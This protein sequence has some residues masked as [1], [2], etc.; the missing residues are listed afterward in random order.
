M[1]DLMT[2]DWEEENDTAEKVIA[3]GRIAGLQKYDALV[4]G[5]AEPEIDEDMVVFAEAI[6]NRDQEMPGVGWGRM[7]RK[8]EK[9]IKKLEKTFAREITA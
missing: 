6:Y 3:A 8:Q 7:A 9:A 4:G 1:V 5:A 2:N